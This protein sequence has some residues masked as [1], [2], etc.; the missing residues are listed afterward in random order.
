MEIDSWGKEEDRAD[1]PSDIV[2][3][4]TDYEPEWLAQLHED[5]NYNSEVEGSRPIKKNWPKDSVLPRSHFYIEEQQCLKCHHLL[6]YAMPM[7]K[8]PNIKFLFCINEDGSRKCSLDNPYLECHHCGN[9]THS[10]SGGHFCHRPGN[11]AYD[12][13]SQI[14]QFLCHHCLKDQ[15][16][17]EPGVEECKAQMKLIREMRKKDELEHKTGGLNCA[18]L[19]TLSQPYI[20]ESFTSSLP[21]EGSKKR[22]LEDQ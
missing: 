5:E 2:A 22:K 19:M 17:N 20:P 1:S 10:G 4:D 14:Y 16:E 6:G 12:G 21:K 15:K 3:A 9:L 7:N 13:P 18:N 11:S 8:L